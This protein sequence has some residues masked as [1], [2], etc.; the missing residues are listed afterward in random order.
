M[1]IF[2]A[3]VY[4]L[5]YKCTASSALVTLKQVL[6]TRFS[7]IFYIKRNSVCLE[8]F[9]TAKCTNV[10]VGTIGHLILRVSNTRRFMTSQ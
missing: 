9:E 3:W 8:I 7:G 2:S 1:T 6:A 4:T 5:W 10:K